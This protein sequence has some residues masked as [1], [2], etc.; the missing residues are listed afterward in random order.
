[1]GAHGSW[2]HRS[3]H[4]FCHRAEPPHCLDGASPSGS[5]IMDAAGNL[6]GVTQSGGAGNDGVVFELSPPATGGSDWTEAVLY[7]F[8]S[9]DFPSGRLAYS[10]QQTGEPYDGASPL[11]GTTL[12]GGKNGSGEAYALTLSRGTW[13]KTALH[14][15]C[16]LD[17]CADGE[18]PS[19]NL[20]I[21]AAGNLYGQ[22][23]GLGLH[24]SGTAYEIAGSEFQV[25]HTFCSQG[26]CSDPG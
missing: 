14:D 8:T 3:L 6:Y 20:L 1:P 10:G 17:R 13:S 7:S 11:Y 2:I 23:M 15:F 21:D 5:L 18:T 19:G 24:E 16:S 25:L 4:H 22:T 26:G 9:L 12:Q